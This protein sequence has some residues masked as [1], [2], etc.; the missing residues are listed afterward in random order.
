M[1]EEESASNESAP[2]QSSDVLATDGGG[3]REGAEKSEEKDSSAPPG[4]DAFQHGAAQRRP[5][6]VSA[7][8]AVQYIDSLRA[9][10]SEWPVR[11]S[12]RLTN[13]LLGCAIFAVLIPFFFPALPTVL[14]VGCDILFGVMLWIYLVSRFG[15]MRTLPPKQAILIWELLVG[16][17][18]LGA[19]I[20]VN[21]QALM[22][23]VRNMFA[24]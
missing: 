16:A 9:G 1:P 14:L 10:E 2:A 4:D 22:A 19:F 24:H 17:T 11:S 7:M 8:E 18:I 15:L 3:A 13:V 23:F 6:H 21:I 5:P 20:T 12:D